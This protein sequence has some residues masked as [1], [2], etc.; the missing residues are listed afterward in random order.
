MKRGLG[1]L[2]SMGVKI[3]LIEFKAMKGGE[4]HWEPLFRDTLIGG[5]G[6]VIHSAGEDGGQVMTLSDKGPAIAASRSVV[7]TYEIS[8]DDTLGYLSATEHARLLGKRACTEPH[9]RQLRGFVEFC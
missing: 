6:F 8:E 3:S 9:L 5:Q 1:E 7:A 2:V 4:R